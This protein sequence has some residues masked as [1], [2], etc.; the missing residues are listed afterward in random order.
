MRRG[1][2]LAKL[3]REQDVPPTAAP[4][5]VANAPAPPTAA[6]ARP[7]SN[8]QPADA[9]V[10]KDFNAFKSELKGI[11][12]Q[13]SAVISKWE[14]AIKKKVAG[15][16]VKVLASKAQHFQPASEYTIDVSDV[17]IG[18][19][20]DKTTGEL[21][22]DL[23]LM[24]GDKKYFMKPKGAV[25]S[26]PEAPPAEEPAG[27]PETTQAPETPEAPPEVPPAEEPSGEPAP[28]GQEE[29]APSG[30]VPGEPAAQPSPEAPPVPPGNPAEPSPEAPPPPKKK[31]PAL[32]S[33]GENHGTG[34]S[35]ADVVES[36]IL[37][38]GSYSV[39]EI[40]RDI[41]SV[42]EEVTGKSNMKPYIL[43]AG[44]KKSG[45]VRFEILIPRS[46]LRENMTQDDIILGFDVNNMKAKIYEVNKG[47][48]YNIVVD[49]YE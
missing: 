18:Y 1:I 31:K 28:D 10:Q 6:P 33:M 5:P 25:G 4:A 45:R 14:Q 49:K 15:H 8:S 41:R 46:H 38:D 2:L 35:K 29:P 43:G 12:N 32:P 17:K 40:L 30:E 39:D 27:E 7:T 47:T 20:Y 22:Y 44:T 42:V 36:S 19:H 9:L 48:K 13:K 24:D 37:N 26:A 3:I 34:M 21:V 23:I 11:E 16:K